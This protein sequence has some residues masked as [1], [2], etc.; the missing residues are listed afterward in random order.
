MTDPS[1]PQ[2]DMPDRDDGLVYV[3]P[4]DLDLA[5]K[6]ALAAGRPLLLRGKPGSGKSSMAPWVAREKQWRYY[7][8]VVTSQ[9]RAR[10]LQWTFD[11]V[12]RLADAQGNALLDPDAYVEPGPLWW[13]FAPRSAAAHVRAGRRRRG[14]APSD[15]TDG[16]DGTADADPAAAAAG[17]GAGAAAGAAAAAAAADTGGYRHP[18][19]LRNAGR[20]PGH[21]V[22]LIDEID[23]A[24][25]DVPNGLLVPLASRG[26]TVAESGTRVEIETAGD[27]ARERPFHR[28]L[29]VITTNEERELP[30]AFLRR[31]VIAELTPPTSVE[32]LVRIAERHL[33]ARLGEAVPADLAL[34]EALAKELG[35]VRED[36]RRHNIRPPS[37]AEYLDALWA[38][39]SLGIGVQSEQWDAVR[40]LT[41]LKP[42]HLRD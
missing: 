10:D 17:A 13:A 35:D 25:P 23:K 20:S 36:A 16:T 33:T 18:Q 38:C 21:A 30:Q 15:G 41:L 4:G 24:D 7:D 37:T 34:A 27:A 3:M 2:A 31:C 32:D 12:R 26:F 42:Q 19:E 29:V 14:E 11:G 5:V 1:G 22:V 28:H 39:R 40:G 8:F 9:T 6:V